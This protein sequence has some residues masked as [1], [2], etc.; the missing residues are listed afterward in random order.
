MLSI[1]D[2]ILKNELWEKFNFHNDQIVNSIC[3][4]T[5]SIQKGDLF[6]GIIGEKFDGNK[7]YD[8]AILKGAECIVFDRR[9]ESVDLRKIDINI[10]YIVVDDALAFLQ[11]LSR[12]YVKEWKSNGGKVICITGSNGKTTTKEMLAFFLGARY[13]NEVIATKGNFNNHIGVP[14]TLLNIKKSHK[15]AVVEIGTNSPGEINFLS[16]IAQPD[17]GII[18]SIGESHLEKLIDI[19]GVLREKLSLFNY[20]SK[21]GEEEK[22][23]FYLKVGKLAGIDDKKNYF[24]IDIG[25]TLIQK[26]ENHFTLKLDDDVIEIKNENVIGSYN[27]HNLSL[28]VAL[29]IKLGLRKEIIEKIVHR[30]IPGASR[31]EWKKYNG[32]NVFCDYYNAN[33]TSMINAIDAFTKYVEFKSE[34]SLYVI[35]DMYELG[36]LS[37]EYHQKIGMHLKNIGARNVVF[38][39]KYSKYLA[40]GFGDKCQKYINSSEFNLLSLQNQNISYVFVKGSRGVK[41]ENIFVDD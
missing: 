31:S 16:E 14:L 38:I 21:N 27:F 34:E 2:I 37:H 3:T 35:G 11:E 33:P 32:L 41:L 8:D 25:K 23:C 20:L 10:P 15:F 19:D 26:S 24:T 18:T 30:F 1:V 7:F 12:K 28:A 22:N 4:D 5:R 17:F 36:N 6:V 40:L 13:P 29:S 9:T 39:G